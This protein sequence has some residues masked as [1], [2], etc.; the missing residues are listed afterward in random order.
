MTDFIAISTVIIWPVIPLFWIPVHFVSKL[1][2][3]L[4]LLTYIMPL[5]AWLPFA[6][7]IYKNRN[8]FLQSKI[9]VAV[10]LNILGIV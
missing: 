6:Y 2:K 3:N 7:F 9:D 4:G 10:G 5:I 1:F 8:I